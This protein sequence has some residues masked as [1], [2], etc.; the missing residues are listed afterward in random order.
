M[1]GQLIGQLFVLLVLLSITY[2]LSSFLL[3]AR[4][5]S[6]FWLFPWL[7]KASLR[8]TRG[9]SKHGSHHL[10][11]LRAKLLKARTDSS[12]GQIVCAILAALLGVVGIVASIPSAILSDLPR[13]KH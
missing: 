7:I 6:P 9:L 11:G 12:A 10:F 2:W 3:L 8:L 1:L 13:H 5:T 4:K